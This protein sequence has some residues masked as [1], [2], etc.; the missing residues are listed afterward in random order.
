MNHENITTE[1]GN[2]CSNEYTLLHLLFI[3]NKELSVIFNYFITFIME[4]IAL[5]ASSFFKNALIS[6][7]K[8]V[9]LCTGIG[10]SIILLDYFKD[11][12]FLR[13]TEPPIPFYA[14]I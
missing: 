9:T 4:Y 13:Y 7:R 10:L 1:P 6:E 14:V 11:V 8:S 3:P 2:T 12:H 5:C